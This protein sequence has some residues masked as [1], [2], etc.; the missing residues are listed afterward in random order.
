MTYN[1]KTAAQVEANLPV[2]MCASHRETY[3][4]NVAKVIECETT[5]YN[6]HEV[7]SIKNFNFYLI[8]LYLTGKL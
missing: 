2:N 5:G 7:E 4:K 8:S 3:M 1:G 6:L